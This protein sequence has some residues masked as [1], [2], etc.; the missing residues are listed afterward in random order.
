MDQPDTLDARS[1][2]A[3]AGVVWPA[4]V[5]RVIGAL[6]TQGHEG[7]PLMLDGAARTAQQAADALGVELGQ[8]AKSIIFR[9]QPEGLHVLVVTAGDR[10]VDVAK[11]KALVAQPHQQLVK[12]DATFV[13]ERTGFAIGGV[14]PLA[15]THDGLT[16][17]D[18]SLQRFERIWAA[19]GHPHAVFA[20]YVEDLPRLTGAAFQDVTEVSA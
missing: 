14:A 11:V 2:E 18:E 19:A 20:A 6:A 3:P 7:Q 17:L 9:L 15:H 8:I 5:S 13:R 16:L 12:A 4:S 1:L 10:R